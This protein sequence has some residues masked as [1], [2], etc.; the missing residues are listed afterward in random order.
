MLSIA[1]AG[2][3]TGPAR[4]DVVVDRLRWRSAPVATDRDEQ[5]HEEPGEARARR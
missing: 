3:G 1:S 4:A 2:G 5:H